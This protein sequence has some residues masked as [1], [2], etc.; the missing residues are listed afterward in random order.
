MNT[1]LNNI[2][3][4]LASTFSNNVAFAPQVDETNLFNL[5]SDNEVVVTTDT[6]LLEAFASADAELKRIGNEEIAKALRLFSGYIAGVEFF[7]YAQSIGDI[8]LVTQA[9]RAILEHSRYWEAKAPMMNNE[10]TQN[11]DTEAYAMRLKTRKEFIVDSVLMLVA[12]GRIET[13]EGFRLVNTF[14]EYYT[15]INGKFR[16]V[17]DEE[18]AEYKSLKHLESN[19]FVPASEEA[20]KL[21]I[22]GNRL[23]LSAAKGQEFVIAGQTVKLPVNFRV[24]MSTKEFK[25]GALEVLNRVFLHNTFT[26]EINGKQELRYFHET[27]KVGGSPLNKLFL[28]KFNR[29]DLA[30]LYDTDRFY[31]VVAHSGLTMKALAY[32]SMEISKYVETGIVSNSEFA[33][34]Y[35]GKRTSIQDLITFTSKGTDVLSWTI[36]EMNK[37]I[38]RANKQ[39]KTTWSIGKQD[40]F[41]VVDASSPELAKKFVAGEGFVSEAFLNKNGFCRI[42]SK[43]MDG[44][45][46]VVTN[47]VDGWTGPM[48]LSPSAFKGGLFTALRLGGALPTDA[49]ITSINSMDIEKLKEKLVGRLDT[50]DFLGNHLVG[51]YATV[52]MNI[53]NAYLVEMFKEVDEDLDANGM[54]LAVDSLQ[55]LVD[56]VN[57]KPSRL[58]DRVM[59]DLVHKPGFEVVPYLQAQEVSGKIVKKDIVTRH[60][61]SLFQSIAQWHSPEIA[62]AMILALIKKLPSGARLEKEVAVQ[63]VTGDYNIVNDIAIS[64]LNI[65]RTMISCSKESNIP[66]MQGVDTYPLE[67]KEGLA[68]LGF[69]LNRERASTASYYNVD[70]DGTSVKVPETASLFT[71]KDD[72]ETNNSFL[73]TGYLKDMLE[74]AKGL[75][76]VD[77]ATGEYRINANDIS[78]NGLKL[79]ARLQSRLLG[80]AFGYLETVG[81]Y[82]VMLTRFGSSISRDT[83][84]VT[85]I[86]MFQKGKK[87]VRKKLLVN[88]VKHPAYFKDA[89]AGYLLI[90]SKFKSEIANFALQ[91]A[92]F[93]STYT[94]MIMENDIDG[95][96]HQISLDDYILPMYVGPEGEFNGVEFSN[97][98][99]GEMEG[100]SLLKSNIKAKAWTMR[101]LHNAMYAAACASS[102]IGSFTAVKYKYEA[103]LQGVES[104]VGTYGVTYTLSE[105]DRYMITNTLARL[106]QTEAM[107]KVKQDGSKVATKLVMEI[108]AP[109]NFNNVRPFAGE[110]AEERHAA[111]MKMVAERITKVAEEWDVPANFGVLVAE[112]LNFAAQQMKTKGHL[113]LDIFNNRTSD[114]FFNDVVEN[115]DIANYA[116]KFNLEGKYADVS[117]SSDAESLYAFLLDTLVERFAI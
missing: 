83:M 63:F 113:S 84:L 81:A 73:A 105:M 112:S 43:M 60:T 64:A 82:Q 68:H 100:C 66:L 79:K 18:V 69:N 27:S 14:N 34:G 20:V 50:I 75:I 72:R 102:N 25:N 22:A 52:D 11:I 87:D 6:E 65:A 31:K 41:V 57:K 16:C 23:L 86:D 30:K 67:L 19:T 74:F 17:S 76:F 39:E 51:F 109:H 29:I 114:K 9:L 7:N 117:E 103:V 58:R 115:R 3:A 15:K 35:I 78:S 36:L 49:N 95:D 5:F 91:K 59:H 33:A 10:V 55:E 94:I 97:F 70:F 38:A 44:G 92:V 77:A 53:S 4:T 98:L 93:M 90:E 46:K 108:V 116:S 88:G 106:C 96:A 45:L 21:S 110:T 56:N 80:K 89:A 26:K 61:A 12:T 101:Q 71:S 32:P 111:Q 1:Q 24:S 8:I 85:N 48:V 42:T 13:E 28:L 104:F 99:R 2:A 107:D 40:I 62:K 54:Q 47:Y 37:V